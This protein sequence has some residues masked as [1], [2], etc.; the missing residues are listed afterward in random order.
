MISGASNRSREFSGSHDI[1]S[2]RNE[3]ICNMSHSETLNA[4]FLQDIQ[5]S[6]KPREW[7][8]QQK[9]LSAD[10]IV[11]RSNFLSSPEALVSPYSHIIKS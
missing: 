11:P 3:L 7:R 6:A 1:T 10:E 8:A 2:K 4:E 9:F 5:E